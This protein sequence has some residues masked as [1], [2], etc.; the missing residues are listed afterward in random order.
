MDIFFY[1]TLQTEHFYIIYLKSLQKLIIT[2]K[3]KL[4]NGMVFDK[5]INDIQ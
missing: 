5:G 4:M 3:L 2:C 1:A